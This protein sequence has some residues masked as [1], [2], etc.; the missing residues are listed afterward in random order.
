[1]MWFFT[2]NIQQKMISKYNKQIINMLSFIIII[3]KKSLYTSFS[4]FVSVRRL[5]NSN[6]NCR[7]NIIKV[8]RMN[9]WSYC[10]EKSAY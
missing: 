7:H 6:K 8:K 1:M 10:R 5:W 2:D 3:M 9:S 4:M